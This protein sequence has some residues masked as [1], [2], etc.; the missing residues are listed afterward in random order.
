MQGCDEAGVKLLSNSGLKQEA[1]KLKVY[2]SNQQIE[3]IGEF[4]TLLCE[5][6]KHTNLIANCDPEVLMREH[7]LDSVALV[8]IFEGAKNTNSKAHKTRKLIDIGSGGGFPGLVLAIVEPSLQVVMVEAIGKKSR[9][10]NEA[11][12]ALNLDHRVSVLNARAEILAHQIK[13]RH[14]FD[15]ATARAVGSLAIVLELLLPLL[16]TGG[17]AL[18]QKSA[19]QL[20]EAMTSAKQALGVLKANLLTTA[21]TDAAIIG[22]ER[23]VL[24]FQQADKAPAL[25]PRQ[26]N[27]L[28]K[29]PLF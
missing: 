2:L 4:C 14:Q 24:V 23:G 20:S 22:K 5:F 8:P 11:V 21:Y 18:I 13:Y 7:I 29:E 28:I 17:L 15:Y 25:Y 3:Q 10:L 16:K 26:W 6:N 12:L 9:F 19:Q 1:E 27:K